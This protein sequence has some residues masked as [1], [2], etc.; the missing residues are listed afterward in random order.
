MQ[1]PAIVAAG[2]GRA[3]KAVY[4][5]NKAYLELAGRSLVGHAVAVLQRVPEVREVWVV[6]QPS[7]L[8]AVLRR[9]LEGVLTK[10]LIIV[11]QFRNLLENAW[12]TYRRLL[13]GAGP[14]GRDPRPEELDLFVLYLSSDIPLATPQEVSAFIRRGLACGCDYAVGLVP[15]EAMEAFYPR[16]GKPGI[17]MAYFNVAE[18]RF[19]QSNLHLVRP[20]RIG[21]RHYVEE[22]Y[23]HRYQKQI[24]HALPLAWRVFADEA[25]GIRVLFY[26]GLMHLAGMLDRH[27]W[28]RLADLL[29]R[30]LPLRR[31]SAAIGS[32]QRQMCIRDSDRV[33][34]R[35]A[36]L[37][38]LHR[39][40]GLRGGRGQRARL[41]GNRRA[42]RRVARRAE[43]ARRGALWPGAV[44]RAPPAAGPPGVGR[45]RG[46]RRAGAT[47]I[48][49][50]TAAASGEA[51]IGARAVTAP[52]AYEV[53]R[54]SA[55]LFALSWRGVIRVS[56]GDRTRWLDGMLTHDIIALESAGPGS[57][58]RA[59]LLTHQGRIV[60]DLHVIVR[61]DSYLL[62]LPLC[63]LEAAQQHL[64]RYV[65]ADDIT[66]R[67]ES[68]EI[69]RLALE[70]PRSVEVLAS[71]VGRA[72]F[73]LDGHRAEAVRLGGAEVLA[74][75]FS[76]TGGRG[77]QLFVPAGAKDPVRAAL[78]QASR[79]ALSEAAAGGEPGSSPAAP[80]DASP[81]LVEGDAALFECL[82]IEAGE[83]AAGHEI[84]GSVLPAELRLDEAVSATKGCYLG[85]EVVT[86]MRTRGSLSHLL[87]GLRLQKGE[88]GPGTPLLLE[89]RRVGELTSGVASPRFGAIALGF[90]KAGLAE[91]GTALDAGGEQAVVTELPFEA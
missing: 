9:E 48:G 4:G 55:G 34:A 14:S 80:S 79:K 67:D 29:R 7:R 16:D 41:R 50:R 35:H 22:M 65:I 51:A 91:P 62:D 82:R 52:P 27:G 23:E 86:R 26:Y 61:P 2:D 11:P 58:C 25:G 90:V 72:E 3:S 28:R 17:E 56:G 83:P 10:P 60:A 30:M 18:G 44:A 36:L 78:L 47:G 71:A 43:P 66:L 12:E 68:A 59:L 8:E 84:D 6:G 33:A 40:R 49:S 87:I 37:L 42:L 85:Q 73:L 46:D 69:V 75:G 1:V 45:Q 88:A 76:L 74:A 54:R 21:K 20:P 70:G 32:L 13:P 5:D 77:V 31:V 38:R 53:V 64:E 39:G 81:E 15:E 19:R 24:R 63:V 57:G 89:G